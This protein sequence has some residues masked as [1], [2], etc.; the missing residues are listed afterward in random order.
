MESILSLSK[1]H[2]AFLLQAYLIAKHNILWKWKSVCGLD[3]GLVQCN[4]SSGEFIKDFMLI[5][6]SEGHFMEFGSDLCSL[7]N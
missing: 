2:K 6:E 4:E 3:S 7:H 1:L 5:A